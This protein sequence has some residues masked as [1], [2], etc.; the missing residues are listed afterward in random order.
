[1][2]ETL[3]GA[4]L[5]AYLVAGLHFLRFWRRTRERLFLYFAVAFWLLAGNQLATAI[6]TDASELGGYAYVLRVL[7]YG[8]ILVG[9]LDKNVAPKP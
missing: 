8:L 2:V 7:G 3:A 6:L 1:M 9:I 4:L 5:F